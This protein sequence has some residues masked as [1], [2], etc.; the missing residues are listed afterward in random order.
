MPSCL[1]NG[2]FFYSVGT[3]IYVFTQPFCK[4]QDVT[5]REFVK[6]TLLGL[7]LVIRF[8]NWW[9]YQRQRA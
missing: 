9:P 3:N 5:Q 8:I 2:T 6:R 4:E 7:E 1:E